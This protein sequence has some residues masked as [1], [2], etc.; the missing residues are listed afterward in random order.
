VK[1]NTKPNTR[2]FW[3][4]N[5]MK[6]TTRIIISQPVQSIEDGECVERDVQVEITGDFYRG[7]LED[8]TS[9]IPLNENQAVRAEEALMEAYCGS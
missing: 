8:W 5:A 4:G 1:K 2:T 3:R 9:E 6:I 7:E